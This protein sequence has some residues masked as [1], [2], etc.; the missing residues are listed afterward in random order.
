MM[1][2]VADAPLRAA[3]YLRI[4]QDREL[5]GLAIERQREDCENVV[6][7]HKWT[8]APEHV[9]TDQSISATDASV[10]RPAYDRLVR[11]FDAREWDALVCW[12]LDRLTRQPRQLEDWIDRAESRGLRI[13]TA[14]GEADL[15]TD[16]GRLFARVKAAVARAEVERKSARQSRAHR[17]RAA[18][19]RPPKGVRALGYSLDGTV[20]A[21]E[22]E[23]V[24]AI[25]T[26][27]NAGASLR[28]IARALSGVTGP[29]VPAVP[30]LPS[31]RTTLMRER[32][33][34]RA[35][36][37]LAPCFSGILPLD[38]MPPATFRADAVEAALEDSDITCPPI[39]PELIGRYLDY[40]VQVGFLP[41][42]EDQRASTREM[43]RS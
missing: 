17:Q 43:E 24:R 12:D 15:G 23:A 21:G 28:S 32:N 16:S 1:R 19:G 25:F 13:V 31:F 8:V 37:A 3:I 34:D 40:F 39:T 42:A 33:E 27:F 5:D 14:N 4:S 38:E 10:N 18:M 22:A 41:S 35:R 29:D 20:R 30:A 11:D 26:A 2:E 7:Q 9:Y 36:E 6:A